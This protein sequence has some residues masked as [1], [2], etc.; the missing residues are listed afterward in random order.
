MWPVKIPR[1][2]SIALA[3]PLA[4]SVQP[5]LAQ[6]DSAC[7]KQAEKR[8]VESPD[9]TTVA[10]NVH[11]TRLSASGGVA[12]YV[13]MSMKQRYA[14]EAR[15][16]I[17][18]TFASSQRPKLVVVVD[19]DIDVRN[20]DQVEWAIAFRCQPGRDVII[21][22]D[23]PGGTL[24]PS[25]DASIPLNRRVGSAM[26]IDA[27]FPFGADEQKAPDVPAGEAC[28]PAVAE[29]GHEFFKVADVPGWQDFNFPELQKYM[30]KPT[31][32]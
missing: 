12:F 13:V 8:A 5:R 7:A 24:D 11:G 22:N 23:L 4:F 28:G 30:A 29:Q 1:P 21:V 6:S 26:G 10:I 15:H 2:A 9:I 25:V 19:P 3:L 16:A 20:P 27:T 18:T 31:T 17:L 14:G 32:S